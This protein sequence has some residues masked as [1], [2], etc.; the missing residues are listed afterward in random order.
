MSAKIE[1]RAGGAF[2]LFDGHIIG[3]NIELVPDRRIVQAWRVV[4]WPEGIYSIARFEL[5]AQGS[6]TRLVFDHT[7]FPAGLHDHLASGW[8]ERYW[9]PLKKYLGD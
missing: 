3:R 1:A 7:S 2:S 4:D 8:Q 5:D 9:A 6:G